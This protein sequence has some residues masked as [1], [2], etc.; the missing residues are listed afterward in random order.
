MSIDS[1]IRIRSLVFLRELL[2]M[3]NPEEQS[4]DVQAHLKS[5]NGAFYSGTPVFVRQ[6]LIELSATCSELF[7]SD[8]GSFLWEAVRCARSSLGTNHLLLKSKDW[9]IELMFPWCQFV[10]LGSINIDQVNAE[11]FRFLMDNA[12]DDPDSVDDIL[13]CWIEVCRSEKFGMVNAAV[14][15]DV[16]VE[17]SARFPTLQRTALLFA[18]ALSNIHPELVSS[19]LTFHLSSSAFPWH[20]KDNTHSF[21]HTSNLAIKDY[22]HALHQ[23]FKTA[24]PESE[25]GYRLTRDSAALLISQILP[26]RFQYFINHAAVILN[27]ILVKLE[28]SMKKSVILF[29]C[30]Q[31]FISY[32]HGSDLLDDPKYQSALT[33]VRK[34]LGWLSL[35]NAQVIWHIEKYVFFEIL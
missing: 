28:K 30:V 35:D 1:E 21:R 32:I 20:Q 16:V 13:N 8:C 5:F 24:A 6:K 15:M 22:I 25:N 7:A 26:Q 23:T 2:Q 12:F 31:G 18:S 11:F 34:F 9:V 17:V 33:V 3:F 29:G 27:F 10:N 4:F 14:L 19:I